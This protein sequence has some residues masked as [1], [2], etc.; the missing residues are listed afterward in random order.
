MT[1]QEFIE[2]L[3]L[4]VDREI[5][6]ADA[7]KLEAAVLASPR[8]RSIY[9]QYCRMQKACTLLSDRYAEPAADAEAVEFPAS[10]AWRAGPLLAG[11][12]AACLL[13]VVGIRFRGAL[14]PNPAPVVAAE[15]AQAVPVPGGETEAM[16]PVYFAHAPTPQPARGIASFLSPVDV[17]PQPV[18]LNWIGDI[19]LAPV[20]F[21]ANPDF[22]IG[23]KPDLKSATLGDSK[24]GRD[25]QQ[26]AEM[27]AFR[28]QR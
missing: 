23:Q 18:Q 19:H 27:A 12:A 20:A 21:A 4:Y 13:V 8:R 7:A 1:D 26:P 2:L 3:N 6:A 16:Q 28:F 25:A 5:S 17:A 14:A 15:P 9:N 22:L 11:L 10:Q 24:D